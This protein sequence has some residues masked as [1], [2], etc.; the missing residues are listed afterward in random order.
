ML[1]RFYFYTYFSIRYDYTVYVLL[2]NWGYNLFC[3]Y[4]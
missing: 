1:L 2:D 4:H 3:H